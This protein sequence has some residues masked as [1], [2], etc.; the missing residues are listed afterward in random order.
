MVSIVLP[1]YKESNQLIKT[2]NNVLEQT[3]SNFELIV[4]EDGSTDNTQQ[5]I[6]QIDDERL[7]YIRYNKNKGACHA[8]NVG[9]KNSKYPIIAFQ[10]SDDLWKPNYEEEQLKEFNRVSEQFND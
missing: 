7:V 6:E 3:F 1:T 10:D 4:V 8:R 5:I 2:I 9:V